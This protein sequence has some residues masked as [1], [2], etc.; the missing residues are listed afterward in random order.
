MVINLTIDVGV[1]PNKSN[2]H[3]TIEI[4][5]CQ[6]Y[7]LQIN[8]GMPI[9][10]ALFIFSTRVDSFCWPQQKFFDRLWFN[11]LGSKLSGTSSK[12]LKIRSVAFKKSLLIGFYLKI[13]ENDWDMSAS[14]TTIV[15][16]KNFEEKTL[17]PVP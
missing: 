1:L 2:I 7:F 16:C 17:F 14:S 11:S 12:S 13:F 10:Q 3:L 15:P 9:S 4:L 5:T 6:I 8:S